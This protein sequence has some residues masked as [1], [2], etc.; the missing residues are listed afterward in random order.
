MSHFEAIQASELSSVNGGKSL[1]PIIE[2]GRKLLQAGAVA[3]NT[4]F[5][6]HPPIK[7]PPAPARIERVR[8]NPQGQRQGGGGGGGQE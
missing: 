6:G 8:P 4:L 3:F 1:T 2:G 5:P 7:P